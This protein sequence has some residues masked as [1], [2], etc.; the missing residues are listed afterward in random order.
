MLLDERKENCPSGVN[1]GW[2][3]VK[4]Y[5]YEKHFFVSNEY[6][7][8]KIFFEFEGVYRKA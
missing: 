5:I 1:S 7:G 6:K 4:D 8:K 2:Y 3:D